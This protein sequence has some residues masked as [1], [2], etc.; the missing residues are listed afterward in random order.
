M[1]FSFGARPLFPRL[2]RS[3]RSHGP[4]PPRRFS[5]PRSPTA[6]GQ[7]GSPAAFIVRPGT[8]ETGRDPGLASSVG[9]ARAPWSLFSADRETK[10]DLLG[11]AAASSCTPRVPPGAPTHPSTLSGQASAVA[12]RTPPGCSPPGWL[13]STPPTSAS[14]RLLTAPRPAREAAPSLWI[15]LRSRN[16]P[17]ASQ[18]F[19]TPA[20]GNPGRPR[21]AWRGPRP[22]PSPLT[23]ARLTRTPLFKQLPD[24][25]FDPPLWWRPPKSRL[26]SRSGCL[27]SQP[28]TTTITRSNKISSNRLRLHPGPAPCSPLPPG[29]GWSRT[30]ITAARPRPLPARTSNL[31]LIA[32]CL[33]NLTQKS[34]KATR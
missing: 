14:G 22:P 31:E 23:W 6:R 12:G 15:P 10:A 8:T 26:A 34:R 3:V 25:R 16:R 5:A 21:R 33:Q 9:G 18:T 4:R 32:F 11:W 29:R 27:R 2:P 20:W 19:C 7:R 17:S 28:P 24:P 13:P 1:G 30:P